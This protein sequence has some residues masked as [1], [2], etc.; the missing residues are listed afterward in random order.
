MHFEVTDC[1]SNHRVKLASRS[2]VSR[3]RRPFAVLTNGGFGIPRSLNLAG[4][5]GSST[6]VGATLMM[7]QAKKWPRQRRGPSFSPKTICKLTL[8]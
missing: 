7:M 2:L 4:G 8:A 6:L 1:R 5:S 3:N